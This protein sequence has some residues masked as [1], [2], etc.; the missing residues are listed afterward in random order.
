MK[1]ARDLSGTGAKI[2]GGR[3][4][5][6]GIEVLYTA[7]NIS[8]ANLEVAVHLSLD[9][10]PDDYYLI[11]I[12]FPGNTSVLKLD[13]ASLPTDWD[14]IPH[15]ESTQL[16]GDEFLNKNEY[17]ALKAPSAIVKQ[18]SNYI[19]NPNHPGFKDVEIITIEPFNFDNRLFE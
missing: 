19:L 3:W 12:E 10:I 4:N 17:L 13:H 7:E 16:I 8:L 2:N 18:E 11:E 6:R 14:S 15:S 1:H 5:S 9:L